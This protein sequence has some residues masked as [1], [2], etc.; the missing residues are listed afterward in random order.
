VSKPSQFFVQ[1]ENTVLANSQA[2]LSFKSAEKRKKGCGYV[3]VDDN[4]KEIEEVTKT[5]EHQAESGVAHEGVDRKKIVDAKDNVSRA[6][7]NISDS[8][9]D[10]YVVSSDEGSDTSGDEITNEEVSITLYYVDLYRLTNNVQ[11]KLS[12][13][14]PRKT[15]PKSAARAAAAAAS[16]TIEST[17]LQK[18]KKRHAKTVK[19]NG[20]SESQEPQLKKAKLEPAASRPTSVMLKVRVS[21]KHHLSIG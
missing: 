6:S 7:D 11:C 14:L 19:R 1:R 5:S 3:W 4:G 18:R 2:K 20:P 9:D 21:V 16:A 17:L 10:V 12:S 8:D 13:I 15:D